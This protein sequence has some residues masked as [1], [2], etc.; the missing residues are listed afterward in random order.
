MITLILL[1]SQIESVYLSLPHSSLITYPSV[2]LR[3]RLLTFLLQL[4]FLIRRHL[5][6]ILACIIP[7]RVMLL[8]VRNVLIVGRLLMIRGLIALIHRF[9]FFH[10]RK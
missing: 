10:P 4:R 1:I 9:R 6:F 2:A 3:Q 8:A 7:E 5:F